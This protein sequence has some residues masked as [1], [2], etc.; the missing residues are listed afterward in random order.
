VRPFDRCGAYVS[1]RRAL[2]VRYYAI[3]TAIVLFVALL[4]TAWVQRDLIR[5]KIAS[6]TV[7]VPPK[8]GPSNAPLGRASEP[9][10]RGDAPW[11]LSALPEC[12]LQVQETRG[13]PAYVRAHFPAGMAPIAPPATLVYADCTISIAGDAADVRR[14]PDRF[15]IPP[16]VTF[17]SGNGQIA[18]LRDDRVGMDLRVYEPARQ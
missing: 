1:R 6:V 7:K 3:A 17:Y 13:K 10:F 16:H 2:V 11:A 8:A 5:L 12:L 18:V 14:G 4:A 9:P 15:R